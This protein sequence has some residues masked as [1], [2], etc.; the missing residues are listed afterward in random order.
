MAGVIGFGGLF[1]KSND[2]TALRK[3]YQD[4]LGITINDYG[5][6]AFMHQQSAEKFGAGA[7]TI[8]SPFKAESE[9]FAP[10]KLDYMMNLMVEDMESFVAEIKAKGVEMIASTETGK[11]ID[12]ESYGKFA[13]IMDPDGRKIE[14]WEPGEAPAI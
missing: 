13:W 6:A 9:Y 2:V 1:F 10:S 11:E 3:W 4:M 8:W 7:M 12:S 5:G 14:L